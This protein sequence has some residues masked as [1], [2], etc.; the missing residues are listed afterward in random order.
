MGHRVG[1]VSIH[2]YTARL[3]PSR[4]VESVRKHIV[5]TSE[6]TIDFLVIV[7]ISERVK[8]HIAME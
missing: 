4:A 7:Q 5:R 2:S 6:F 3:K 8:V 1:I